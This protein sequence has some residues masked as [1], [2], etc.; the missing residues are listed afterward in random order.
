[1]LI[2]PR[3]KLIDIHLLLSLQKGHI[4][5]IGIDENVPILDTNRAVATESWVVFQRWRDGD[6]VANSAA[7]TV[8]MEG[9]EFA[10]LRWNGEACGLEEAS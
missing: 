1:M 10:C 5:T 6:L 3:R 4:L 9:F 8:S 2:L 7:V